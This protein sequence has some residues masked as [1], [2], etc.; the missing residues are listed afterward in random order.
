MGVTIC[1]KVMFVGIRYPVHQSTGQPNGLG[2][3]HND[4]LLNTFKLVPWG[5][6]LYGASVNKYFGSRHVLVGGEI[7][8]DAAH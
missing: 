3:T 7:V 2:S 8:N 6:L 5:F 1:S 4:L